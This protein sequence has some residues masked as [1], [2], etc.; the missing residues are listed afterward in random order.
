MR[1]G[2]RWKLIDL[3]AT[4]RIGEHVGMKR[5]TGYDGPELQRLDGALLPGASP[6]FDVW[7]LVCADVAPQTFP[8]LPN[9][10][11]DVLNVWFLSVTRLGVVLHFLCPGMSLFHMDVDDNL[12]P[13]GPEEARLR[14]WESIDAERLGG[15]FAKAAVG[16]LED[17]D[18]AAA[19]DLLCWCLQREPADRP[20]SMVQV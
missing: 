14:A 11:L 17:A 8:P 12:I 13:G 7:G 6:T 1:V 5:S 10:A 16:E 20:Q 19:Q 4:V 15:A 18:I 3:D 2:E 9:G